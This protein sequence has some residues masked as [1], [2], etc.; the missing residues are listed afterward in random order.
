V[1]LRQPFGGQGSGPHT[2]RRP[3]GGPRAPGNG[4]GKE[5]QRPEGPEAEALRLKQRS[6]QVGFGKDT[7]GYARYVAA[8]PRDRRGPD[9]PRT[10]DIHNKTL[11][12]RA[13]DGVLKQW[14][15]AL[16]KWDLT[17]DDTA[18][19]EGP[20]DLV[21]PCPFDAASCGSDATPERPALPCESSDGSTQRHAEHWWTELRR[22]ACQLGTE[23]AQQAG[24]HLRIVE[25]PARETQAAV[26]SDAALGSDP[27]GSWPVSLRD[28]LTGALID[29]PV[30]GQHCSH[31]QTFDFATFLRRGPVGPRSVDPSDGQPCAHYKCPVCDQLVKSA[32]LVLDGYTGGPLYAADVMGVG[33]PDTFHCD[34]ST[35]RWDLAGFSVHE[36]LAGTPLALT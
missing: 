20:S 9:D 32:D 35:G 15:R 27:T 33:A 2:V 18:A 4:G 24:V 14:R 36:A 19:A 6:K 23:A 11:S 5:Q 3:P 29:V 30:R 31:L 8:V 34:P 16:H 17:T 25:R 1:E 12:K 13:F 28:P 26:V 10:P 7:V 21:D 22:R